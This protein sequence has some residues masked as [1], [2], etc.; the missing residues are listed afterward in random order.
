MRRGVIYTRVSYADQVDGTSLETQERD[1]RRYCAEQGIEV[2]AVFVEPG[3]SAKTCERPE[4]H[5]L[6]DHCGKKRNRVDVLVV[7]KLD[8]LS[9]NSDD[10]GFLKVTLAGYGVSIESATEK[11]SNDAEGRLTDGILRQF[12]EFENARRSQRSRSEMVTLVNKGYWVHMGPIGYLNARDADKRP[13]LQEDPVRGPLVRRA[14]ELIADR[15]Y[16]QKAAW[17]KVTSEG[18]VGPNNKPLLY[19]AF[20]ALLTNEIYAGR[21]SGTLTEGQTIQA[22]FPPLI[23]PELFDRLQAVI[24]DGG[25]RNTRQDRD[26]TNFPLRGWAKCGACGHPLTASECVG[27][28]GRRY[29]YYHC[30]NPDCRKVRVRVDRFEQEYVE[31]LAGFCAKTSPMMAML[32]T[33]V[34]DWWK[35]RRSENT[36]TKA[37]IVGRI[38]QLDAKKSRLVDAYL[39]GKLDQDLFQD[40]KAEIEA[41]VCLLKCE[42]HDEHL[43]GLDIEAV[44]AAAEVI[45]ADAAALWRK[46][47]LASRRRLDNLLFPDGVSYL[48][49]FRNS[50]NNP[51][52]ATCERL[53]TPDQRMAP[54]TGFEP[55]LPG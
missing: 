42:E 54:P 27:R 30:F 38:K 36:I 34:T 8:R 14:F 45:L 2:L 1:C 25:R 53:G 11:I 22:R 19:Q 16:T 15:G 50:G 32:R 6:L 46:L 3:R 10:H 29:R 40:K 23:P 28:G 26:N 12:A 5:R 52:V 47:N 55:V 37:N 18:L 31:F 33:V 21:I 48:D 17:E 41:Q 24:A 13:I 51:V 44:L 7:H 9:R 39:D 35:E 49:G 4:L 43:D 20:N